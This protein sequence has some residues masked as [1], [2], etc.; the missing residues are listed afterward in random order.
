[1]LLCTD[2]ITPFQPEVN[3]ST[4]LLVVNGLITDQPGPYEVVLT[5]TSINSTYLGINYPTHAKVSISDDQGNVEQ[6]VEIKNGKFRTS[7]GGIQGVIGRSYSVTVV[8]EDGTTYQSQAELLKPVSQIS[9][10][11]TIY[12]DLLGTTIRGKF[13]T[14]IETNDPPQQGDYYRWTWKHFDYLTFCAFS[15]NIADHQ[16][17]ESACC[18]PCWT[19]DQCES[20]IALLSDHFVN[21]KKISQF[22][23]DIPYDSK[24]PYFLF[25]QQFSLTET[26]YQYW[27]TLNEQINVTGGVFDTPPAAVPGNLYRVNNKEEQ[28]LGYFGAS[29]VAE[30]AIYIKR[31]GAG[32][33]PYPSNLSAIIDLGCIPCR[34]NYYRTAFKPKGW[35]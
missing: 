29:A 8:L 22:L 18:E 11:T 35:D 34:E 14:N 6:L 20:C 15:Q 12:Q 1:V 3:Y 32:V 25:I 10:A 21:G 5:L 16:F 27:K 28:V 31:D 17:H 30:K 7:A 9:G 33:D 26:A 23:I 2:C 24:T 19:I 13:K 4:P